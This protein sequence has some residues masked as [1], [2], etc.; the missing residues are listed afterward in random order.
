MN[1]KRY[2]T[3]KEKK[4]IL[5]G[6][7]F[8][9][10]PEDPN[11]VNPQEI[12]DLMDKLELREKM[13]FIYN[14]IDNLCS[15]REIRRKGGLTK[16]EFMAYLEE[17]M[18]DPESRDGIQT[19]YDVFAEPNN[20]TLP[21]AN[22]GRT[23][24]EVGDPEK[25]QEL[26][27]LL[28]NADMTGRELTFD[29]FYEIMKGDDDQNR[30]LRNNTNSSNKKYSR[31]YY[32]NRDEEPSGD[33]NSERFSD[34]KTPKKNVD[35]YSYKR[36][37]VEKVKPELVKEEHVE[38]VPEEK[39]EQKIVIEEVITTEKKIEEP[40][41]EARDKY[42]NSSGKKD[43]RGSDKKYSYQINRRVFTQKEEEN[44]NVENNN[45]DKG[46]GSDSKRYHRRYRASY[47][48]NEPK[49]ESN[50]TYNRYR[51]KV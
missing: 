4:E 16:D 3:S 9:V 6:L 45:E 47:K 26:K 30:N 10:S 20:D 31:K 8:F 1:Q 12:K 29:E 25:D 28:E 18:N 40:I 19:L 2:D 14:L 46:D 42:K 22:F 37:E 50:V 27:E 17:K 43:G 41:N 11:L 5:K 38:I 35:T 13:P 23:A 24:R 44:N 39:I 7:E 32:G 36:V 15:K 34:K 51:R 33:K 21:M 49:N 48:P